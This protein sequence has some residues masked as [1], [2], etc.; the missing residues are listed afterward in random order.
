MIEG[1]SGVFSRITD[2]NS[3][4]EEIKSIG[5]QKGINPL[6]T[7]IK[8]NKDTEPGK[9][10]FSEILK[11]VLE[12][13]GSLAGEPENGL[14][15]NKINQLV[16]SK[17]DSK[18][19]L[20]MLYKNLKSEKANASADIDGTINEA[21]QKFGLDKALI[22]AV[23]QQ[24]S[25]YDKT[26][27]SAKGAMGLMQLMPETAQ[28]LGV[29][30]PYDVR[31]NILG[32]SSYLKMLMNKYNNNLDLSL[33]AYNAGPGAVDKYGD[34]PPFDETQDYVKQV[35]KNYNDYKNFD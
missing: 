6:K 10:K 23:I 15:Y 31:Q 34:I 3:R 29:N 5:K 20:E 18:A 19:L 7:E 35:I 28:L 22:K 12:D 4:I 17:N 13:N 9:E 30:N 1:I 32:G 33:A 21:S 27:T 25:G 16:G 11:Q 8:D 24:E 14:E 26:A 2:I